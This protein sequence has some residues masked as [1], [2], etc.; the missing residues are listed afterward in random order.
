MDAVKKKQKKIKITLPV[1]REPLQCS[2]K[3]SERVRCHFIST[4]HIGHLE[5]E[6]S[7]CTE[8]GVMARPVVV[9]RTIVCVDFRK[10]LP[11]LNRRQGLVACFMSFGTREPTSMLQKKTDQSQQFSENIKLTDSKPDCFVNCK[12][13]DFLVW[14]RAK[15]KIKKKT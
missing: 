8:D 5:K 12:K 11:S 14:R 10:L 13:S 7:I 3:Y 15:I 2:F 1:L 4:S 9:D 6:T